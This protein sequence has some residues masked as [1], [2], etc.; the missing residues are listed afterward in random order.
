MCLHL[1]HV[2]TRTKIVSK[3]VVHFHTRVGQSGFDI[4]KVRIKSTITS[5]FFV[6]PCF[7]EKLILTVSQV[8]VGGRLIVR[9]QADHKQAA[10][11]VIVVFVGTAID[12]CPSESCSVLYSTLLY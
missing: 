10:M 7:H 5:T 9:E 11:V 6:P 1:L 12:R 2:E 8:D 4:K 3:T